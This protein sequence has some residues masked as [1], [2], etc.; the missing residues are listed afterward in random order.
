MHMA[1]KL[2]IG[3]SPDVIEYHPV[4]LFNRAAKYEEAGFDYL[5]EGDHTLPWHHTGGHCSSA[6]VMLEAYLATTKRIK[7]FMLVSPIGIRNNPVDVALISATMAN[8]HP[9]R[10]ALCVGTGEAMNERTTVGFWPSTKE[11]IERLEE[12][13]QVIK[14]CWTSKDYFK[15]KGKYFKPFFYM[16]DKAPER[17]PLYCAAN[18]PR[19]ARIAGKYADGFVSINPPQYY[20][21]TI[22]PAVTQGAQEAGRDAR[23]IERAAWIS[24]FYDPDMEKALQSARRYAGL[25]IPECYH[26]IDDPRIIEARASLVRDDV[27]ARVFGIVTSADELISRLEEYIKVGVDHPI[28]AEGS[29]DPDHAMPVYKKVIS[30]LRDTYKDVPVR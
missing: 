5:W 26:S 18:G 11:R 20:K 19:C 2:K 8:L 27:L 24:I 12:A 15:F 22:I 29:P 6:T 1:T 25:L 9:G 23:Q 14:M 7:G 30:Y 13:I 17:I 28:L 3:S 10:F 4:D 21:D 16:Y